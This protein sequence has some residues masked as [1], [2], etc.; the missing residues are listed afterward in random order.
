MKDY[1]PTR[2]PLKL[3]RPDLSAREAVDVIR[4]HSADLIRS[5][6]A[7]YIASAG[8]ADIRGR[9][10]IGVGAWQIGLRNSSIGD[11]TL[12]SLSHSGVLNI[13]K[14]STSG[15]APPSFAVDSTWI[16]ST[17]AINS[18]AM[19]PL[20][21]HMGD[22]YSIFMCLKQVDDIGVFWEIRRSYADPPVGLYT[23][24]TFAVHATSGDIVA[25]RIR[26]RIKG[27]LVESRCRQSRGADDW[28]DEMRQERKF[29]API[30]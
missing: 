23:T 14:H 9:L 26:Q 8:A 6:H 16:D 30:S 19:E 13:R 15:D 11:R 18:I 25:E 28:I 5:R 22:R 12:L 7:F 10:A 4:A 1:P 20:P 17:L 27:T 21:H 24:Q 29:V 2:I 3:S